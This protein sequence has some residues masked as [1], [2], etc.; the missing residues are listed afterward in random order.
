MTAPSDDQL[1]LMY[2][3]GDPRAFEQLF[4]RYSGMVY[5]YARFALSDPD[6]A[7]DVLQESF[8]SVAD[9]AEGYEPR[10]FFKAWLMRIARNMCLNRLKSATARRQRVA[11]LDLTAGDPPSRDQGPSEALETRERMDR[12][13][14]LIAALPENQR[15]ALLLYAVEQMSYNEIAETMDAPV[16]TVKTLI[17][18]ARAALAR[19][20][21]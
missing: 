1:M 19:S 7:E 11:A 5:N 21:E 6:A 14:G 2:R 17:H 3:A 9:A 12:L 13:R 8:L 20:F 10:G 15:D 18:R 4:D 16:N